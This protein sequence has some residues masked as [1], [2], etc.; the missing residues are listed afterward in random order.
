M[1]LYLSNLTMF[2]EDIESFVIVKNKIENDLMEKDKLD[3]RMSV[4]DFI[5]YLNL[6][7]GSIIFIDI[8]NKK[9]QKTWFFKIFKIKDDI[10]IPY[11]SQNDS[12]EFLDDLKQINYDISKLKQ[13]TQLDMIQTQI[14]KY[15]IINNNIYTL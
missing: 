15:Y 1:G 13:K 11:S 8:S 4:N 14:D 10:I 3:K 2:N 6:N 12:V 7:V 5:N 9:E